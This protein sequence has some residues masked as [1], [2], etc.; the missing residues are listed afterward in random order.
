MN[1]KDWIVFPKPISSANIPYKKHI[2]IRQHAEIQ[3]LVINMYADLFV[4]PEIWF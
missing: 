2:E 1:A 4:Q 3:N